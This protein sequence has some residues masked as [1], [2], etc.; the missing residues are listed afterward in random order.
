MPKGY[1]L[2]LSEE[3]IN[4]I[5]RLHNEGSTDREIA[6]IYNIGRTTVCSIL[7]KSG[8]TNRNVSVES[9]EAD[10]MDLFNRG[11]NQTEISK[12]LHM[13]IKNI[14]KILIKNKVDIYKN[15]WRHKYNINETYFDCIDTPNKAYILGLLY[16][17]GNLSKN[18]YSIQIY[19]QERDKGI[20]EN[21]LKELDSNYPLYFRDNSQKSN[22][23]NQY[24]FIINN[25]HIYNS[26]LK[27]GLLPNK[28]L[29]LKYPQNIP[30]EL[31]RHFIR[32]YFDGDGSMHISKNGA[33]CNFV[34]TFDFCNYAKN[35]I[36]NNIDINCG[37]YSTCD[38]N[39]T[40]ILQVSGKVQMSKFLSWIYDDSDLRLDRKYKKYYNTFVV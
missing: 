11:K 30:I 37:V 29:I 27:Y 22:Q 26:L 25:K 24:G 23:Q 19:L 6:N 16:A 28:S 18:R 10:V 38:N 20:L 5:C 13:D 15:S 3:Q 32:G 9:K 39:V 31:H 1:K 12:E 7:N 14:R 2:N 4:D 33:T 34:G 8:I 17:D 35:I 36:E 40:S 21:I